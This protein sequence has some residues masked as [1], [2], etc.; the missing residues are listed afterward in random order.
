MSGQ[1]QP[2]LGSYQFVQPIG[3]LLQG[4]QRRQHL[5]DRSR[6]LHENTAC[7]DPV[8]ELATVQ[9][10]LGLQIQLMM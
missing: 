3:D 8:H 9:Q 5:I 6:Q 1:S 10:A 7:D 4:V 2:S